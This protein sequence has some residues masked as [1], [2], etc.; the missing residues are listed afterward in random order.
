MMEPKDPNGHR[1]VIGQQHGLQRFT[2][3]LEALSHGQT[4][5]HKRH[6]QIQPHRASLPQQGTMVTEY[7][8]T[9]TLRSKK[10]L[11]AVGFLGVLL[12]GLCV[13]LGWE[14]GHRPA[15][16]YARALG[17]VDRVLTQSWGN[18]PKTVQESLAVTYGRSGMMSP[19]DRQAQRK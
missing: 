3:T 14:L 16:G 19:G 9:L 1:G 7:V 10:L 15:Q 4:Q 12:L 17:G 11:W 2:D 13:G 8:I 5:Q 6:A 18:L